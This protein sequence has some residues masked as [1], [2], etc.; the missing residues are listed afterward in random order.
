MKISFQTAARKRTL[1]VLVIVVAAVYLSLAAREVVASWL[2]SRV[3]LSSLRRAA[4][5]DPSNADYRDHLGRYYDLVG[6]DPASAI[7]LYRAAVQLNPHSARYWFDLASAYQ[8]MGDTPGQT[9]ALEHAIHADAMTPDVAWEAANLYLVQGENEKALREFRVV[10]ANDTSLAA[11]S[12]QFCWRIQPDVDALLRD[13]VPHNAD[14]YI[15]FLTLLESRQETDG[16]FK[17]WNALMQTSEP[18][19]IRYAFEYLHYLILHKEVDKAVEAWQQ[20]A[21]RF[22]LTGYLPT[23]GNLIVNGTFSFDVLNGGFDWQYQK[24]SGVTLTLDPSDFHS[25]RRSLLITFDGPGITDAGFYQLVAVQPNTSYD[26]T[27]YYKNGELEGAGGP[28]I[29][30]QDMYTL[31]IYYDSDEL[32][33]AGFWKSVDGEFTTGPDCKLVVLHVRRLPAGNP[34]RGKL[35]IDDFHL[36]RKPS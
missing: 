27:A 10:M 7:G 34:I 4:W 12:I 18:F 14:A 26:F 20:T 33:A 5:L 36:A 16:T 6:R 24:Q 30:I 23:P 13:V 17:V 1:A 28:H 15:A 19:E 11:S 8:V 9:A 22:G 32:N 35:W 25:G 31:A 29:T 21:D 2:G 3:E